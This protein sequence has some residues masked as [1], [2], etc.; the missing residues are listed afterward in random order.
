MT[1]LTLLPQLRSAHER[2]NVANRA[3]T[4][5]TSAFV[6]IWLFFMTGGFWFGYWLHMGAFQ[7]V[8]MTL[9]IIGIASL[10]YLAI[11]EPYLRDVS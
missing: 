5:A 6:G 1:D 8:H 9:L 10:I 3:A 4:L 11:T 7:Q 2:A